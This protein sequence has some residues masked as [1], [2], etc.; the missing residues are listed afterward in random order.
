MIANTG[1]QIGKNVNTFMFV[2]S[3]TQKLPWAT[4]TG[5]GISI[6]SFDTNNGSVSHLNTINPS[7]CGENPSSF[8][9]GES[10]K[11]RSK[12]NHIYSVNECHFESK[13]SSFGLEYHAYDH[14][15]A[16]TDTGSLFQTL[17]ND[18]SLSMEKSI[19]NDPCYISIDK[20]N[21]YLYVSTFGEHGNPGFGVYSINKDNNSIDGNLLYQLLNDVPG[22]KAILPIQESCHFHCIMPCPN[23]SDN[24]N[25]R[26][27][28]VTNTGKFCCFLSFS[29]FFSQWHGVFMCFE[30]DI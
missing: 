14:A 22:S 18:E 20:D 5:K 17:E 15:H 11:Q 6:Y 26:D 4:G 7:I 12:I 30:R 9:I 10:K 21:K 29:F 1:K 27:F 13:I 28:Y 16:N 2:G 8:V 3:Y 25:T 24:Y 23:V 19:G